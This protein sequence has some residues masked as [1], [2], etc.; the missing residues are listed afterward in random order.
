MLFVCVISLFT[1][2]SKI[3]SYKQVYYLF[4]GRNRLVLIILSI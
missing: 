4:L 3:S 2:E 1:V